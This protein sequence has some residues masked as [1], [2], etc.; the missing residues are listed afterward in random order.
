MVRLRQDA[1]ATTGFSVAGRGP[2][3]RGVN[4]DPMTSLSRRA[5]T[6]DVANIQRWV[7]RSVSWRSC[8][9]LHGSV[10]PRSTSSLHAMFTPGH[11]RRKRASAQP[12]VGSTG[13]VS[14]LQPPGKLLLRGDD[15]PVTHLHGEMRSKTAQFSV[16]RFEPPR[17]R[18]AFRRV[19][20]AL[21]QWAGAVI[22]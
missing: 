14:M 9:R 13:T 17:G 7:R 2:V 20:W 10:L 6:G 15:G 19:K 16:S 1:C 4:L 12:V 21:R 11:L 8:G 18:F 22:Q 5:R 3:F